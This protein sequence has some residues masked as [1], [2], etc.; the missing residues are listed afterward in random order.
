MVLYLA[1]PLPNV[2]VS[3]PELISGSWSAW[4]SLMTI[5]TSVMMLLG[6]PLT[7]ASA[8]QAWR[9]R[10]YQSAPMVLHITFWITF[11][12]VAGGNIIIHERYRIMFT[13][14]LFTC[15]WFGY[16]RCTRREVKRWAIPWFSLL[17]AGG[18]FYTYYKFIG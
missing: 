2:A 8:A 1:A 3:V 16:T 9:F 15:V 17:A 13:L 10:R 18:V 7:L 11:M 12:A 14:L 4:Q 6:L 5:L